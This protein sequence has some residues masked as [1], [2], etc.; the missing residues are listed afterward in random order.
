MLQRRADVRHHED[1]VEIKPAA[2]RNQRDEAAMKSAQGRRSIL[3][4]IECCLVCE[5][6]A[7]VESL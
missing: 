6:I 2:K 4:A 7:S 3:D 1:V 5:E